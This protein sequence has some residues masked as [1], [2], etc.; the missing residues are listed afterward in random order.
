MLLGSVVIYRGVVRGIEKTNKFLIPALIGL[1]I[2]AVIRSLSL[3]GSV[4]GL[5]YFFNPKWEKL[6]D[7]KVWLNG[8]SQ[9]AW[10]TG[11]GW[12][13]ILTYATYMR[14]REDIVLNS[15]ITGFGNNSASLLSG[16]ALFPAVF[17]LAPSLNLNAAAELAKT[18]PANTGLTF[19]W[20]PQLFTKAPLGEIFTLVFFL[21]LSAAALSSLIS[22]LELGT[23]SFMDA[24]L[25][26]KPAIIF[27]GSAGFL[28]GAPSALS[29]TFFENQDWVWSI[30]LILSGFFFAFAV[31]KYGP[32]RFRKNLIN[33]PDNDIPIGKWYEIIIAWVI[34]IEF[35]ILIV[36]WFYQALGWQHDWWN[37]FKPFSIGTCILQW[38]M[39]LGLFLI[40]NRI[41]SK[42][43]VS[44]DV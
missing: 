17:A 32:A 34:P 6:L 12:G 10:S 3:D 24:G 8:L 2:L 36:W 37:P 9:S 27:V 39:V 29:M 13:L 22:M 28:L 19:I 5:N 7:Y 42:R 23:R 38:A 25:S 18:G 31:I 40:F 14:K 44:A 1:L 11:A 35:V 16:L 15:Y 41:I 30:G 33:T 43:T 21:L 26:R 4:A 20:M